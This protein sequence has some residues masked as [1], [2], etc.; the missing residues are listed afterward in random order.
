M[1]VI[2]ATYYK[3]YQIYINGSKT[4]MYKMF[5]SGEATFQVSK[6]TFLGFSF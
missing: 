6:K 4:L 1:W 2:Q 3:I 5:W